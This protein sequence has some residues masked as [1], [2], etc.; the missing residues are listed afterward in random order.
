MAERC[1]SRVAHDWRGYE[2]AAAS[3]YC[4]DRGR[5]L[6]LIDAITGW[7]RAP[8]GVERPFKNLPTSGNQPISIDAA[9]QKSCNS[10]W[11]RPR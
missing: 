5:G 8:L 9:P 3:R 7:G 6:P 1:G 4:Y 2:A 10:G 11:L